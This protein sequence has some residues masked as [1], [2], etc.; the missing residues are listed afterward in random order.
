MNVTV[1]RCLILLLLFISA[2]NLQG[3][4]MTTNISPDMLAILDKP[5]QDLS[6]TSFRAQF[7]SENLHEYLNGGAERYLGYEVIDL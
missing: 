2:I 3:T 4:P 1:K 7:L 5:L 6:P